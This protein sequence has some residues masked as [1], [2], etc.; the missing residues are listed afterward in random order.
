M[1]FSVSRILI[2]IFEVPLVRFSLPLTFPPFHDDK[3]KD[4]EHG[5]RYLHLIANLITFLV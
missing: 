2:F 5:L 3:S 1:G 4:I